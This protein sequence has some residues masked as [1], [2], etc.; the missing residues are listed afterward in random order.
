M[1]LGTVGAAVLCCLVMTADAQ[2]APPKCR[3][4]GTTLLSSSTARIFKTERAFSDHTVATWWACEVARGRLHV[5]AMGGVD[6]NDRT[7]GI[8]NPA[9]N[10][11]FVAY[12]AGI[13]A[14]GY[15][16]KGDLVVYDMRRGS[17]LRAAPFG[18]GSVCAK[19]I[20]VSARGSA[21]VSWDEEEGGGG[22][23]ALDSP[24]GPRTLDQVI[25]GSLDT[26]SLALTGP[27]TVIWQHGG[28][29]RTAALR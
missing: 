23:A 10:G 15:G 16:C 2:A 24:H 29:T 6:P 1:R 18:G 17:V 19:R 8:F 3:T 9:L 22:V 14:P 20:V 27:T 11:R 7:K 21:A 25:D 5:L 28:A 4:G 12:Q 13:L 26:G